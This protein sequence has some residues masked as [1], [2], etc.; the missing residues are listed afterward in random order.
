MPA[1]TIQR[2]WVVTRHP[3]PSGWMP[4]PSPCRDRRTPRGC[5]RATGRGEPGGEGCLLTERFAD[6]A[7]HGVD[8]ERLGDEVGTQADMDKTFVRER[9]VSTR[10]ASSQP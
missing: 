8:G 2:Y 7:D 6:R 5:S 1:P 4:Y 10:F 9:T 3:W